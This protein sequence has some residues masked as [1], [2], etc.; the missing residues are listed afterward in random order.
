[1][2]PWLRVDLG[3]TMALTARALRRATGQP[4]ATDSPVEEIAYRSGVF[5][6]GSL[7][8]LDFPRL[9]HET[10]AAMLSRFEGARGRGGRNH[11][12]SQGS[13]MGSDR[14]GSGW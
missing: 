8:A 2:G 7:S 1:M 3:G 5:G 4:R 13:S 6:R 11:I 12:Y 9:R 14:A 10:R